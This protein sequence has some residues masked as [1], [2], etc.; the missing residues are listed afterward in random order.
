MQLA[1]ALV[2]LPR[3]T[4]QLAKNIATVEY[5]TFLIVGSPC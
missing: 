2:G 3:N 4:E 1:L 5:K